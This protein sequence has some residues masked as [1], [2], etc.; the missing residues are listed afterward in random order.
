M[1]IYNPSSVSTDPELAE[2]AALT[3][4]DSTMIVGDGAAWVAETGATL[5]TSIGVGSGD[6]PSFLNA[7]LGYTT[8]ATVVV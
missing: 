6:S 8:T 1:T 2:I 5:R 3:P 7:R 4:S